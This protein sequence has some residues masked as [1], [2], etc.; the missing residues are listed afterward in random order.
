M[1]AFRELL[2]REWLFLDGGSGTILQSMGLRGGELPENWNLTKPENVIALHSN[3]L[4]AGSDVIYT[5]T[6]GANRL[7]FPGNLEEIVRAAVANA[8]AARIQTGREDAFIALDLGPTGRLLEPVGDLPFEKAVELYAEIVR[9]GVREGVDLIV[10]E[11]M[12]SGYEAKAAV[13]AA[14]ENSDLPVMVTVTFN[15]RGKMLTGESPEC[16]AALL[17]GL[18]VDALGINCSL[19]PK[20]MYP[21]V[22]EM[23]ELTDL[24]LIVKPN[25]GL[26]K[27]KHGRTYYDVTADEFAAVMNDMADLGIQVAG[28]CCGTGPDH[29]R[30]T[31]E[32]LKNRPLVRRNVRKRTV[33][34]SGTKAVEIGA[35][36]VIIGERINPTGKKRF[37]QA[38]AEHDINYIL[39]EALRQEDAGA[40]ILDVNLGMPGID[41]PALMEETVRAL[42]GVTSLPLQLDSSDP[43]ALERGMR[44]YNGIPM[45]NSVNGKAK[46]MKAVMP[47]IAKYG[48]VLVGLCLDENGI[49]DTAGGR[50]EIAGRICR[51]AEEFGI[52]RRDIV[53]DGLAMTISSD[54]NSANTALETIRRARDELHVSTILGVSN[55]SFGLPNRQIIN[56]HFLSMAVAN[57]LSCAI[58]NPNNADMMA[59]FRASLALT[60]NDDNCM[61]YIQAYGNVEI[62]SEVRTGSVS[63]TVP[64]QPAGL[65]VCIE[66]GLAEQASK[67]A[68]EA[69][70]TM[71]PLDLINSELVPA[72]DKVGKGFEQGTLFLPQ[73]LMSADAAKAAFAAIKETVGDNSGQKKGR[74]ILAT[75]RGDIHDIGKNIVKVMLENYGYEVL[76]LG[77]DVPPEVIAETAVRE[78]IRLVGL[79]ALMTTTVVSMEETI[80]LL[81]ERKPDAKIVVGGAVLT[82]EYAGRIG[83]DAYAKDAMA[84][85]RYADSVF[86]EN[87]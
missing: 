79:S 28:G 23:S 44:V 72:L 82:Q 29:I 39:Q 12:S 43:E 38:L 19:G 55:I 75:V 70:K 25:A 2:G 62:T 86:K 26:P 18:R 51:Q 16:I 54:Q 21:I 34:T 60:G 1:T 68:K 42:Q 32:L 56:S 41:E 83:A 27:E 59:A 66:R 53:I 74:V 47:L 20:Q 5:N 46:N 81:R 9:I 35:K 33:V 36:P 67:A 80:R 85:V 87:S 50:L 13:L 63:K 37:R 58:I 40:D 10:I 7:K 64:A 84:T 11:T 30:K 48:G 22:R 71:A 73:L 49:P 14:K 52:A 76:D 4:N 78:N 3:Y 6:F 17:E 31:I 57:G 65:G 8:G 15:E 45:I 61:E 24:P 77:K 69:L